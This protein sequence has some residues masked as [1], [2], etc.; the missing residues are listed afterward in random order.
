MSDDKVN[1]DSNKRL[2]LPV[3]EGVGKACCRRAW[4]DN[5][6]GELAVLNTSRSSP[7]LASEEGMESVEG[8]GFQ[9]RQCQ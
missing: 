2:E 9:R 3:G 1:W 6:R 5:S 8:E 7:Q 4:V